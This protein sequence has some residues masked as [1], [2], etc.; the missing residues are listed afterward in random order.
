MY[1]CAF[2]NITH[3]VLTYGGKVSLGISNE[4]KRAV[5]AFAVNNRTASLPRNAP[6]SSEIIWLKPELVGTAR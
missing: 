2:F 3:G 5:L 1:K 6:K 4:D